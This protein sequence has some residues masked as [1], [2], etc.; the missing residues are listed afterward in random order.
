ME[1]TWILLLGA[2]RLH[3]HQRP[4]HVAG[5]A[6]V[7]GLLL[8]RAAV[9]ASEQ[10]VQATVLEVVAGGQHR[11][12]VFVHLLG[13]FLLVRTDNQPIEQDHPVSSDL[14]G[15]VLPDPRRTH[16]LATGRARSDAGRKAEVLYP[17]LVVVLPA[18]RASDQGEAPV[19]LAE[20]RVGVLAREPEPRPGSGA[21]ERHHGAADATDE[22]VH[23]RPQQRVMPPAT[24]RGAQSQPGEDL[25][26]RHGSADFGGQD[27][28]Q[29]R[30]RSRRRQRSGD[31]VDEFVAGELA[32][33]RR[34][35]AVA[36][37][38]RSTQFDERR[39]NRLGH[40]VVRGV[41]RREQ[42]REH[43]VGLDRRSVGNASPLVPAQI[44]VDLAHDRHTITVHAE[45]TPRE[46]HGRTVVARG[47]SDGRGGGHVA[48][49]V[50]ILAAEGAQAPDEAGRLGALGPAEG[51]G[52]VEDQELE[53]GAGEDAD[54]LAAGQQQ[55][56]LFDVRQQDAWLPALSAHRL[57]ARPFLGRHQGDRL[58]RFP[59]LLQTLVVGRVRSAGRQALA[60]HLAL[61]R[62]RLPDVHAEGNATPGQQP[63]QPLELV[64]GQRVH[65]VDDDR[66]HSRGRPSILQFEAAADNG[67]EEGLGLARAGAGRD[68]GRA[69]RVHGSDGL[70]LMGAQLGVRNDGLHLRV[71]N[72]VGHQLSHRRPM[73]E[74]PRQADEGPLPQRRLARLLQLEQRPEL[75]V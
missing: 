50:R 74:G 38:S 8:Q 15:D 45:E 52:L 35:P 65:R 33:E 70:F 10:R 72:A 5:G 58:A 73:L 67:V 47:V 20:L 57:S 39:R 2:H 14:V 41:H 54:I 26:L 23:H 53:W 25:R 59:D 30:Q 16:A 62:R 75:G 51:V 36:P 29:L 3:G 21:R 6:G 60:A 27:I 37:Q 13:I 24:A 28:W 18:G 55:L 4:L 44:V 43:G 40:F 48:D 11:I 66:H 63:P 34:L 1:Q 64:L 9:A 68:Q 42:R 7:P 49:L 56:Q 17:G 31:L 61:L 32:R 71:E 46:V 69:S 19:V 12:T 22:G